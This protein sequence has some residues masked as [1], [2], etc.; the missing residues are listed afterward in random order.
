MTPLLQLVFEAAQTAAT[1]AS[2][3]NQTAARAWRRI[4][5]LVIERRTFHNPS[6]IIFG[7]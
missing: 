2:A 7:A 4:Q 3:A 6:L 5:A 1:P